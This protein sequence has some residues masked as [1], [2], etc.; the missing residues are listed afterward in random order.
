MNLQIHRKLAESETCKKSRYA[1]LFY[2]VFQLNYFKYVQ[3]ASHVLCIKNHK[4]NCEDVFKKWVYTI[5]NKHKQAFDPF[6]PLCPL[7]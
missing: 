5:Y 2:N 7:I 4:I 1:N 6:T 3:C